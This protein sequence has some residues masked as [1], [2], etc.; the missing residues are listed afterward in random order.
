MGV[1]IQNIRYFYNVFLKFM[2]STKHIFS[3]EPLWD[4]EIF[5]KI[6]DDKIPIT[7]NKE[8]TPNKKIYNMGWNNINLN[9]N[10]LNSSDK[11]LMDYLQK[12]KELVDKGFEGCVNGVNRFKNITN[13]LLRIANGFPKP[14][15]LK[16]NI[17]NQKSVFR[18]SR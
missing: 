10:T 3:I 9:A 1:Q 6:G 4:T 15:T 13:K 17:F 14:N 7:T 12:N 11:T 16:P 5:I 2:Y 18:I 8:I